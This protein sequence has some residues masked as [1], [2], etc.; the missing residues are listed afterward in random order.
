[1]L[2]F[3]Y[4]RWINFF[5]VQSHSLTSV[6]S[7]IFDSKNHPIVLNGKAVEFPQSRLRQQFALTTPLVHAVLDLFPLGSLLKNVT[8]QSIVRGTRRHH[9]PTFLHLDMR[10]AVER[11]RAYPFWK[12]VDRLCVTGTNSLIAS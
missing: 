1:M 10:V 9:D 12:R 3:C 6:L 7:I 5:V 11:V 4:C 8:S 2:Q